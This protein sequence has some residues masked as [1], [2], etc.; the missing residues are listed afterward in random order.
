MLNGQGFLDPLWQMGRST[1]THSLRAGYQAQQGGLLLQPSSHG[2]AGNQ[3][4]TIQWDLSLQASLSIS[5]YRSVAPSLSRSRFVGPTPTDALL[6]VH[7]VMWGGGAEIKDLRLAAPL[8]RECTKLKS[9]REIET[10]TER[11]R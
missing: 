5:L 7:D 6:V 4:P 9:E 8:R 2:L 3:C 1:T 10:E 11:D